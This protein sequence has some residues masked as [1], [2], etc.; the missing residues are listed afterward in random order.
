MK[1]SQIHKITTNQP[2]KNTS[3]NKV[4]REKQKM[5]RDK[6]T[7]MK[8]IRDSPKLEAKQGTVGVRKR[9]R[10]LGSDPQIKN[11]YVKAFSAFLGV[12]GTNGK[13]EGILRVSFNLH[14]C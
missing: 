14:S 8:L 3:N 13:V 1:N 4:P 12:K 9:E 11:G 10:E 7:E 2:L 6:G 5:K